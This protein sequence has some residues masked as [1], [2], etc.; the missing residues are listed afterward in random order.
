MSQADLLIKVHNANFLRR[1]GYLIFCFATNRKQTNHFRARSWY[2][3]PRGISIRGTIFWQGTRGSSLFGEVRAG[4]SCDFFVRLM[5]NARNVTADTSTWLRYSQDKCRRRSRTSIR[6]T[7]SRTAM[8]VFSVDCEFR[9]ILR[10][11]AV[12]ISLINLH[13]GKS[14]NL[15]FLQ[16]TFDCTWISSL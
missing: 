5:F 8:P 3:N 2:Y 15:A 10:L 11:F 13:A 6:E 12:V 4:S 9:E 7:D 1:R 16:R 14:I